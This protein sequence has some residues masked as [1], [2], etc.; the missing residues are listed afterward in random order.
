MKDAK[1]KMMSNQTSEEKRPNKADKD[2]LIGELWRMVNRLR[3]E[4]KKLKNR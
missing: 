4:I 3:D 2:L 1:N